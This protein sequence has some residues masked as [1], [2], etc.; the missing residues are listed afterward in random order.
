MISNLSTLYGNLG[1]PADTVTY[2]LRAVA[3]FDESKQ[4]N[5]MLAYVLLNLGRAQGQLGRFQDAEAALL[6]SRDL[7]DRF[8]PEGDPQR[9]S[10]R[11]EIGGL[12][13][14]QERLGD[15]E[16]AYRSALE[17]EPKLSRPATGWRSSL[18]AYLG[19]VYRDQ[20][21][22]PEAERLLSEAVKLEEA[23]GNERSQFVAPKL[24]ELASV[25]RREIATQKRKLPFCARSRCSHPH[26]IKHR[27]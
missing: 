5:S 17:I 25:L 24:I 22:Y 19:M 9:I 26:S 13:S 16:Q 18:L 8:L 11:I 7:L 15:A 27:P 1:R 12:A 23:G 21:R 20:G 14:G 2:S 6:R 4:E 3:S 10:V